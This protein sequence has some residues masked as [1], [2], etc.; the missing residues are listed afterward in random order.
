[1]NAVRLAR[2]FPP[3]DSAPNTTQTVLLLRWVLIIATSYLVVFSRPLDRNPTSAALYVAA[4]FA[5]NILL[6]ELRS[7]FRSQSAFNISVVLFDILMVS[8]GL[9]LTGA[10]TNEIYVVYFLVIFTSALTERLL[11]VVGAALLISIVHLYTESRFLGFGHLDTPA[12]ILRVP[13]LFVVAMF[14][15]H[16]VKDVRDRERE[17]EEARAHGRRMEILSGISH[18]LKNPLGVVQSLATLLLD[19]GA[20]EL[21]DKQADFV[22][23]IHASTR[24]VGN[25]ALN[26]IDAER[27]DAGHLVL[28]RDPVNVADLVEDSLLHARSASDLK[29]VTLRCSVASDLPVAHLD[30]VQMERVIANVVGNA[31]KF[32]PAGGTVTLS[33]ARAGEHVVLSVVDDGPGMASHEVTGAFEK[34]R[35]LSPRSLGDGSGLGLFIVKGIVEAHAGTVE[36]VSTVGEGTTVTMRLPTRPPD[37]THASGT[38]SPQARRRWWPFT[39]PAPPPPRAPRARAAAPRAPRSITPASRARLSP[40]HPSLWPVPSPWWSSSGRPLGRS[41][42]PAA[43]HRETHATYQSLPPAFL[44][45]IRYFSDRA[46]SPSDN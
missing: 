8:L 16:L 12:Y 36:I 13:F 44:R 3:P 30:G 34:Y 46:I 24:R 35:T 40:T 29:G 26:L 25:F 39:Q 33:V 45:L 37:A 11:L 43:R 19:G 20:G 6:T 2:A 23:R 15:G 7:F 38:H 22:R 18:D 9:A 41:A 21:T 14:F 31:I 1:M 28:L 42:P 27:I 10:A 32:T 17:A 5:S 4:Y